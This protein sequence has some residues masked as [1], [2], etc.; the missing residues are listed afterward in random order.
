MSAALC[1]LA[2]FSPAA[3]IGD[4]DTAAAFAP[5]GGEGEGGGTLLCLNVT[6]SSPACCYFHYTISHI[7][8]IQKF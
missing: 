1:F 6:F 4:T 5:S 7:Y 8:V 3:L 2:L